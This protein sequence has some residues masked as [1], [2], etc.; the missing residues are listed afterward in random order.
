MAILGS[1]GSI[2]GF[3]IQYL[4]GLV[5]FF[6]LLIGTSTILKDPENIG[7]DSEGT[8]DLGPP[9]TY[10]E[11]MYSIGPEV[12]VLTMILSSCLVWFMTNLR[13]GIEALIIGII[14]SFFI[15]LFVTVRIELALY[16]NFN[17]LID[18]T[19]SVEIDSRAIFASHLFIGNLFLWA[20]FLLELIRFKRK[21]I[22]T[23]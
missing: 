20:N 17:D 12:L 8:L 9:Q 6:G 18:A 10:F 22:L 1:K 15:G 11:T 21:N 16:D 3:L 23:K 2:K 14:C 13:K 5:A 7:I 4:I 19:G